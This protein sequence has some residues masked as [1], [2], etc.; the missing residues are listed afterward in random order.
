MSEFNI[1]DNLW[2]IT[3]VVLPFVKNVIAFCILSSVSASNEEVASSNKIIGLFFKIASG[4]NLKL[5]TDIVGISNTITWKWIPWN[6]M[7]GLTEI[8]MKELGWF[9]TET[10]CGRITSNFYIIL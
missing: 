2:A 5:E 3:I 6:S 8:L 7:G 4:A 9:E 10:F 1:V